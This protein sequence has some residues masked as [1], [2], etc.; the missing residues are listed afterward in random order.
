ML[1]CPHEG[2]ICNFHTPGGG[3]DGKVTIVLHDV[4]A[5]LWI[6]KRM[7]PEGDPLSSL[8]SEEE[9]INILPFQTRA[10]PILHLI[11]CSLIAESCLQVHLPLPMPI[12][13]NAL[14]HSSHLC[15]HGDLSPWIRPQQQQQLSAR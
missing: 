4:D 7:L 14:S 11:V 12:G 3:S 10:P 9:K 5:A 8:R 1:H 2:S 6:H 13:L 15:L